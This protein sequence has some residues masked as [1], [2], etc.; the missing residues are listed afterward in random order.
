MKGGCRSGCALGW[1]G[2]VA[3][4]E[5][6]CLRAWDVRR[7]RRARGAGSGIENGGGYYRPPEVIDVG[8][9]ERASR[10]LGRLSQVGW[11]IVTWLRFFFK[12]MLQPTPN[13]KLVYFY[14]N[15]R[16][17][18]HFYIDFWVFW[19]KGTRDLYK[20]K[21]TKTAIQMLGLDKPINQAVANSPYF[22][23][24]ALCFSHLNSD[25]K[26]ALHLYKLGFLSLKMKSFLV[27]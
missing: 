21:D 7:E 3:G 16:T 9:S 22:F 5:G 19:N 13:R 15:S 25:L 20:Q 14:E 18:L 1:G 12:E 26:I 10:R 6:R 27:N 23:L 4:E 8:V 2:K 11:A 17:L 24:L